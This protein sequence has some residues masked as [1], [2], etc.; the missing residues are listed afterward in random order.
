[1]TMGHPTGPWTERKIRL[2]DS[3]ESELANQLLGQKYDDMQGMLV[4]RFNRVSRPG[5][6]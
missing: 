3:S 6:Y 1:M 2:V 4:R 5:R